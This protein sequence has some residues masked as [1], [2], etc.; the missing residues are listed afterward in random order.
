MHDCLAQIGENLAAVNIRV[1][2]SAKLW[3]PQ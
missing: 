2:I 3:S 1:P